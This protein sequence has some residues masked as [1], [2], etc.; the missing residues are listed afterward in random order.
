MMSM[1][2]AA[3]ALGLR[4]TP[5]ATVLRCAGATRHG[6]SACLDGENWHKA[7]VFGIAAIPSAI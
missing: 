2:G 6:Q 5:A 1:V 4:Q 3:V 7:E